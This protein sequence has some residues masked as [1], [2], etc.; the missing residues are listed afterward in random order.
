M[1]IQ[2]YLIKVDYFCPAVQTGGKWFVLETKSQPRLGI[3]DNS[4][5]P[6]HNCGRDS[7]SEACENDPHCT[8]QTILEVM[9]Y[10]TEEAERVH[11]TKSNLVEKLS[12]V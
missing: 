10:S 4:I 2:K 5:L 3:I 7:Y 8:S 1:E 9:P 12:A 11:T 6:P